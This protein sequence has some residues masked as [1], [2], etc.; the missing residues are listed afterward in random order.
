MLSACRHL[1]RNS[2]EFRP[3]SARVIFQ[4]ETSVRA[5]RPMC[6]ASTRRFLLRRLPLR[7]GTK[8]RFG[9]REEGAL[10]CKQRSQFSRRT[11]RAA[12]APPRDP[13]LLRTSSFY[14]LL[15]FAS[16]FSLCYSFLSLSL[17]LVLSL[18][19][20]SHGAQLHADSE[21]LL[22]DDYS[23]SSREAERCVLLHIGLRH[24]ESVLEEPCT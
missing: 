23:S 17:A 19:C 14:L 6:G 4:D 2:A 7:K 21:P 13:S 3:N 8:G 11:L 24:C 16:T 22:T 12:S 10:L 20:A 18:S 9:R 5:V 15:L 1:A